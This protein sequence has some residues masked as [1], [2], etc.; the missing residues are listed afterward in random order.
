MSVQSGPRRATI[1]VAEDDEDNRQ[2]MRLLLEMRGYAVLEAA[3][4]QT[5]VEVARRA[6]P[7]VI[8]MDL[9]MPVLNGLAATRAIRQSDDARLSRVPVVA[10][11]AYDPSQHR[12]VAAAA[13]CNEYIVK[14]VD[15][16]RL[17]R[18]IEALLGRAVG[19]LGDAQPAPR[20]AP[21]R[22]SA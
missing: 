7:D 12:N 18:L 4:G 1:L 13:G 22:L 17:E 10:L 14:P 20:S 15:Y 19:A 6:R 3:D 11:S 2:I 16:D 8:L 21:G 5:A 9:R